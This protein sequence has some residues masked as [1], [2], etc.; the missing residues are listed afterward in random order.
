MT[1]Q[2]RQ[3]AEELLLKELET[4]KNKLKQNGWWEN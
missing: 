4:I 2:E 1:K 3:D